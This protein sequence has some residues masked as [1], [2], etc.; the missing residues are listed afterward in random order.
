[1]IRKN[2][3]GLAQALRCAT[4]P[5]SW[6]KI[7]RVRRS[8]LRRPMFSLA[9]RRVIVLQANV[10][11]VSPES[12]RSLVALDASCSDR[13]LSVAR[14]RAARRDTI[15]FARAVCFD[16]PFARRRRRPGKPGV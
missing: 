2:A 10:A 7:S 1:M 13:G 12:L 6:K 4:I 15:A 5:A 9:P 3:T 14:G 11:H 16:A 8:M